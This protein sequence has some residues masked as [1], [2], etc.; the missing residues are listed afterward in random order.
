MKKVHGAILICDVLFAAGLK[1]RS[2]V[3][4]HGSQVTGH[5]S[6]VTGHR[7][8]VT[9]HRSQVTG[10]GSQVTGQNLRFFYNP[11]KF[12]PLAK[13]YIQTSIV[14]MQTIHTNITKARFDCD[15]MKLVHISICCFTYQLH[16]VLRKMQKCFD[17]NSAGLP[18]NRKN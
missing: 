4:G 1:R 5:R 2:R 10:H 7:S 8:Q 17:F 6:R 14:H 13:L 15:K 12:S 16:T 18:I 3:T 9:G 11:E